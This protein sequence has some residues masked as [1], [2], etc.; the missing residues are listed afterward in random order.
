[1]DYRK[2]SDL[3]GFGLL[4][5]RSMPVKSDFGAFASIARSGGGLQAYRS[6]HESWAYQGLAWNGYIKGDKVLFALSHRDI[7]GGISNQ[8]I[9]LSSSGIHV[10]DN[11]LKEKDA[12][13]ET[14]LITQWIRPFSNGEL[15]AVI[16]YGD[17]QG[18][19]K[20]SL[21][22]FATSISGKWNYNNWRIFGETVLAHR[23][24]SGFISGTQVRTR[25][26][27]YGIAI[28]HINPGFEGMRTNYF[29]NWTN[30]LLGEMENR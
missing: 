8:M 4:S 30:F 9:N 20:N 12:L 15:G 5:W 19:D 16:G 22:N 28:R 21:N 6:G 17:W 18:G 29:R 2:L 13:K 14:I 1:M 3:I 26:L 11:Q 25:L 10:S 7:D 27:R 24:R 23:S